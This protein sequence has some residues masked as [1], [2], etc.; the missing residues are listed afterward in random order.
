MSHDGYLRELYA[1][2]E[3]AEGLNAADGNEILPMESM[4][5]SSISDRLIKVE[6][7][8][9]DGRKEETYLSLKSVERPRAADQMTG[10]E[11]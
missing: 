6:F 10:D 1:E 3:K 5:V 4:E 9:K 2:T 8:D 7:T 11:P